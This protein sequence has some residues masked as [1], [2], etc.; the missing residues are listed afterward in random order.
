MIYIRAIHFAATLVASG[1]AFFIVFVAVPALRTAA[2]DKTLR[3]A[4]WPQ[5]AFVGWFSLVLAVGSG[6]AWLVLTASAMSGTPPGELTAGV[7][8][9]VLTQT[10]FGLAA[11]VRL[12]AAG[13]LAVTFALLLSARDRSWIGAVA[14]LAAAVFTGA[15][16]FT[17]H[18][19][20]GQGAEGI[21]HPAADILHLIASAAWVG[22]LLPLALL[23]AAAGKS[24]SLAV[25]RVATLRFSTLGV[26]SVGTLLVTGIVNTWYLA[27]SVEAL[28][29]TFYGQL[30]LAKI[31][32]FFAMVAIAAVNRQWLTPRL[33]QNE[34][35][36]TAQ[37]ALWQLR[38]NAL[39]EAF[40]GFAVICLVAVL[41][42]KPPGI[43]IHQHPAYAALPADA[44]FVHIH[45]EQAMADVTIEPGH[46]GPARVT[47]RLWN[48]DFE[49]IEARAVKFSLTSPGGDKSPEQTATENADGAWQADRIALSQPGNWTVTVDAELSATDHAVLA[50]PIVIEAEHDGH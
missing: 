44:A 20:G 33:V 32:A 23:L 29:S 48:G 11:I 5:L 34:N 25:A 12:V 28:T 46:P 9:T 18:A 7:L 26:I 49:P 10:H 37:G 13:V 16:A 42:T 27:G 24:N 14:M 35:T 1:L 40:A 47:I 2:D 39:I 43:H 41:G 17:G 15:L 4:L 45:T 38:R 31:A 8:S 3:A 50:A 30:L 22:A 6:A 19:L 36:I 21:V